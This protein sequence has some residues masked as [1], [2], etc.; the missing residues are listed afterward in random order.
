VLGTLRA[1]L[2]FAEV[3]IKLY[4]RH[5]KAADARGEIDADQGSGRE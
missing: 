3:P 5:R 4:L 2:D 1:E